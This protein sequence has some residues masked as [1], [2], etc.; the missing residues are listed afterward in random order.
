[1]RTR[2]RRYLAFKALALCAAFAT[3]G[4]EDVKAILGRIDSINRFSDSF[5]AVMKIASYSPDAPMSV[6]TYRMYTKGMRKALLVFVEPVKDAGKK[7]ALNGTSLWFYFPKAR[8]SIL[9]RPVSTLTGS[10]AVGD[11]IG[12]PIL[13]LYDFSESRPT[14]DGKGRML[15][16][17]ARSAESPYGK[18]EYEYRDGRIAS[19]RS[20]TRSGTLLKTTTFLEY[21]ETG[22]DREYA[23]RIKIQNAVYPA[24]YS[25][26]QISDLKGSAGFPDFYFTPEGL[27]DAGTKLP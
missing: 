21:A 8:Q 14:G 7:I 6:A 1:M 23:T 9:V 19:Q 5:S 3:I 20:F 22:G 24:Y 11:M 18:V 16:F 10:V 13:E 2:T 17:V 27:A 12:A 26:I 4:Q 15:S 25:L